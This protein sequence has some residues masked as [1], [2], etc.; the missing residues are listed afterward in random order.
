MTSVSH[1]EDGQDQC[2]TLS[3]E[4][5]RRLNIGVCIKCCR[6]IFCK[7]SY[8]G[9]VPLPSREGLDIVVDMCRHRPSS[10]I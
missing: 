6:L 2:L 4:M 5:W 3:S 8:L 9:K 7:H 1:K 10:K